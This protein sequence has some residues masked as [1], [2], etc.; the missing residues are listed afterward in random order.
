MHNSVTVA[1]PYLAVHGLV[2]AEVPGVRFEVDVVDGSI[3][4]GA[5]QE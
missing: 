2:L 1:P 4:Y 5:R 3:G